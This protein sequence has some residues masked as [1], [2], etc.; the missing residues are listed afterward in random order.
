MF[1]PLVGHI[2]G[3]FMPEVGWLPFL[4]EVTPITGI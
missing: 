1:L 4:L 2:N 3:A